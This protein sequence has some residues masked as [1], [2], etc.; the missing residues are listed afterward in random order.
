M[1]RQSIT[2]QSPGRINIIGE[3]TDY[4]DGFVLPAAIDKKTVASLHRNGH[5]SAC[6]I[7]AGNLN[8]TLNF[9]LNQVKPLAGGWQNYVLGVVHELQKLGAQMQG[10]D[11]SFKGDVPIGGG[12]SSSASLECALA[13]GLNELFD[14]GLSKTQ[15][16]KAAQLAEHNFVGIKCGIMD[17]FASMMGQKNRVILLDCRS[18]EYRYFPLE[19]GDYQLLLLNTN[20]SHSLASSEYNRRRAECEEGVAV[21]QK[22]YPEVAYLRDVSLSML[23]D[24]Q[25]SMP[26][27]IYARCRHVVSENQ[28][29]LEATQAL[30]AGDIRK[31]GS[32]LYQSHHS[33]QHDYAVS[34]PE[35]DFLVDQTTGLDFVAG[36]RMM[37]G[38]F[39]GCTI[40]ILEKKYCGQF[41]D[42]VAPK[43]RQRFGY[44]LTPYFV[45]IEDGAGVVAQP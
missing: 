16:I 3:H 1:P 44:D 39:G 26:E 9:G 37:G 33:L 38:G 41:V 30:T 40:N 28:R 7:T 19:L 27:T 20:V 11:G 24:F 43:Y 25:N 21:I 2:V 5:P 32:L 10:F 14:L 8:E 34:C 31:L 15:L 17:Q 45:S 4:N 23:S 12:M 6:R 18:L 36:S 42:N 22:K 29:V 35:L 13:F